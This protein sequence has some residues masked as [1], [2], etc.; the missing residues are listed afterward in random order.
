MICFFGGLY[1]T[2]FACMEA[3][4]LCGWEKTQNAIK[5]IYEEA[6]NILEQSL[7]DD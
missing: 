7:K 5:D 2:V 1:P 3:F 6:T 4:R